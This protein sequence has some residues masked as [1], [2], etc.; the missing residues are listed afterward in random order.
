MI[1]IVFPENNENEFIKIAEELGYSGLCFIYDLKNFKTQKPETKL[2]LYTA[3][4]TDE[5][6]TG[7]AKKLSDI[8][9]VKST[10]SDR[11]LL[12]S[13]KADVLFDLETTARKDYL[14]HRA[15]GLN[16]IL[17]TILKKK[18][19]AIAFSFS[20]I[21]KAK[22]MLRSQILGR[23]SQNI[24]LA[25]KYKFKLMFAS[26]ASSPFEMRSP[27][28][29]IAFLITLGM[30]PSEARTALVAAESVIKKAISKKSPSYICEGIELV[31]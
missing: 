5:K 23:I 16:Q 6:N 14:H 15:S 25:R 4:I 11:S 12:E 13:G 19:T 1:D 29:L 8:V 20:T 28:D 17:C 26:F 18:D 3:I 22:D 24:V 2:K 27:H 30:H 21:L 31:E 10:G 7:K 9:L